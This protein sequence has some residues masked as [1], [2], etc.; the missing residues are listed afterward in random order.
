MAWSFGKKKN[1]E[2]VE[3]KM[4]Q[5]EKE[6]KKAEKDVAEK[7]KD[8]QTEKD[9]V[10]ES[11]GEQ[12]KRSG[13]ENSQ[14]AKDRVD[15][16][17]GTKKA[18]EERAE[19]RKEEDRKDEDKAPAWATSL[20]SSMEKIVGMLEKLNSPTDSTQTADSAAAERM[21]EAFGQRGGVFRGDTPAE[22]KKM[23]P[24]DV[25]KAIRKIM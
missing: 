4:T 11:V 3:E 6:I 23:T 18:D 25:A 5:D 24:E 10:D 7:G 9:R 17:E 19:E 16:S 12:E 8:S 13:N 2:E 1:K 14:D 20:V 15:E 21:E 22:E